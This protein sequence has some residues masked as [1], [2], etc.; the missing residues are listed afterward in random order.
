MLFTVSGSMPL[1][2]IDL[3][4]MKIRSNHRLNI[5]VK[6][7]VLHRPA[8]Y[9]WQVVANESLSPLACHGFTDEPVA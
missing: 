7:V 5:E 2:P 1:N 3:S 6:L 8:V 9:E 4:I